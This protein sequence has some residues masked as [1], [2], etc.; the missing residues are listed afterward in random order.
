MTE[1]TTPQR[2]GAIAAV[3]DKDEQSRQTHFSDRARERGGIDDPDLL[4]DTL[5]LAFRRY[6]DGDPLA[7]EYVEFVK[8]LFDKDGFRCRLFRFRAINGQILYA[9]ESQYRPLTILTQEQVKRYRGPKP[10]RKRK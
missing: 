5:C 8:R 10:K 4:F 3:A 9:V 7:H 1:L 2:L 6:D